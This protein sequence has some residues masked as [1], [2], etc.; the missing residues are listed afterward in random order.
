MPKIERGVACPGC[1]HRAAYIACKEALGRGRGRVIC[2]DAGCRAV[3]P[4]HPAATACDGGEHELLGRYRTPVPEGGTHASPA[5][6]ACVHFVTD[7]ALDDA[8]PGDGA[9]GDLAAQGRSTVLAVLASSRA[10]LTR[11]SIEALGTRAL[12]LGAADAVIVDPFDSVKAQAVLREALDTPGVRA[13]IFA[14]PCARLVRDKDACEPVDIDRYA[15]VGCHRCK[16]ITACPAIRFAPPAYEIDAETCTGC[17]L[18]VNFCRTHVIYTPRD[19]KAPE[20]R[21]A[22]RYAAARR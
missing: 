1:P 17:D 2:G 12:G 8:Q 16:Q 22:L 11:E 20:E 15:C 14:S 9:L 7:E 6:D 4:M 10:H 18:C 21:S 19:R 5:V 3:G 13:V